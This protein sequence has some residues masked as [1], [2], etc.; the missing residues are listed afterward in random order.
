MNDQLSE[1]LSEVDTALLPQQE[2]K[3]LVS[4]ELRSPDD[5]VTQEATTGAMMKIYHG[6]DAE[7][8]I[9]MHPDYLHKRIRPYAVRFNPFKLNNGRLKNR[10]S[11][12]AHSTSEFKCRECGTVIPFTLVDERRARDEERFHCDACGPWKGKLVFKSVVT[13]F[14]SESNVNAMLEVF[15]STDRSSVHTITETPDVVPQVM[16]T[17]LGS[18]PGIWTPSTPLELEASARLAAVGRYMVP[19]LTGRVID[20]PIA[21]IVI[22]ARPSSVGWVSSRYFQ[23]PD[24]NSELDRFNPGFNQGFPRRKT[25][26]QYRK[27]DLISNV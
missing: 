27:P 9:G 1:A 6:T 24:A 16:L 22:L 7:F 14:M 10:G 12:Q 21:N 4:F 5:R 2:T 17:Y 26:S 23:H 11:F 3:L 19:F 13:P 18:A 15:M 20:A 25:G 8:A